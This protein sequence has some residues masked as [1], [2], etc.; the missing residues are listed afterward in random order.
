M[1][2]TTTGKRGSRPIFIILAVFGAV[3]VLSLGIVSARLLL[4]YGVTFNPKFKTIASG[5]PRDRVV[6]LL[7]RPDEESAKFRLGQREGYEREYELAENSDSHYYLIW[8]KGIDVVYAVGFDRE[9]RV[10][11]RAVGGT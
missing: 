1:M 4:G 2:L 9:D 3:C 8:Y 5:A 10:T 7:G 11:I 6:E